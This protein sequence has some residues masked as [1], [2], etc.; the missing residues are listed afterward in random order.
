MPCS[1]TQSCDF[2][3]HLSP[4]YS[5][6]HSG[7]QQQQYL[8]SHC[9]CIFS[10]P[11]TLL[12][13]QNQYFPQVAQ[14]HITIWDVCSM[15]NDSQISSGPEICSS[16]SPASPL[17]SLLA[18]PPDIWKPTC[19]KKTSYFSPHKPSPFQHLH[20]SSALGQQSCHYLWGRSLTLHIQSPGHS[21]QVYIIL[22]TVSL[23][24][25]LPSPKYHGLSPE[26][27]IPL[28]SH[29]QS[30]PPSSH[31]DHLRVQ[32]TAVTPLIRTCNG[33]LTPLGVPVT[34]LTVASSALHD[35]YMSKL[36]HFTTGHSPIAHSL[37]IKPATLVFLEYMDKWAHSCP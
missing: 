18:C 32:V 24:A 7:Y 12:L 6:P 26:V 25:L 34:E 21:C 5:K 10:G 19:P 31:F 3:L 9:A 4:H 2:D 14:K 23:L 30:C 37:P 11:V 22:S 35:L 20:L 33:P 27:K 15:T 36:S 13:S 1:S 29:F 28:S 16:H 8:G 17:T